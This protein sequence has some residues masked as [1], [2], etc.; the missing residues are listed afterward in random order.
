MCIA[1]QLGFMIA[2][3]DLPDQPPPG[4]PRP[5]GDHAYGFDCDGWD[6]AK[7]DTDASPPKNERD[8]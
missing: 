2:L 3:A 6:E 8:P 1:C 4:F 7:Q 5:R